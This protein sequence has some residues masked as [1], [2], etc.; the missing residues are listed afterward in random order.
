M[1][2][3]NIDFKS[4]NDYFEIFHLSINS[5]IPILI[6]DYKSVPEN[7]KLYLFIFKPFKRIN[8]HKL[9]REFILYNWVNTKKV[10][11]NSEIK[12]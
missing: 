2:R 11:G 10:H 9:L 3:E 12:S 6:K 5:S 8:W 7:T 1:I 4:I